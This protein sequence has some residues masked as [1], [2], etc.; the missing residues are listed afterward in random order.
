MGPKQLDCGQDGIHHAA[1]IEVECGADILRRLLRSAASGI[2][3]NHGE[4]AFCVALSHPAPH[5]L[6]VC[7]VNLV[8]L[9]ELG[10]GG[11]AGIRH[12]SQA[13]FV[14]AAEEKRR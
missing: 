12:G 4:G 10:A 1:D 6:G 11:T 9:Y 13:A 14:A 2:G 8:G 3:E 5:G 7:D